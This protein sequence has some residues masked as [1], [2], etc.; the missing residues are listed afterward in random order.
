MYK[1]SVA[2]EKDIPIIA[3][4]HV[5]PTRDKKLKQKAK[6]RFYLDEG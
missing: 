6:Y 2:E 1:Y 5:D 4:M 3:T